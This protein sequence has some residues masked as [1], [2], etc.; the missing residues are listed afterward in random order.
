M[1][2]VWLYR[3]K[4]IY[5]QKMHFSKSAFFVLHMAN[6]IITLRIMPSEA[7][8]ELSEIETEALKKINGYSNNK[9]IRV[10]I[11]PIAFG[12]K[13]L[14]VIFTMDEN[15]N[16]ESLENSIREIPEVASVEAV[17]VRRAVG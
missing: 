14:K 1:R 17:D 16:L 12:L 3:A 15:K 10:E 4:L 6:V 2:E 11:E 13:A 5:S 8:V 9:S 7:D